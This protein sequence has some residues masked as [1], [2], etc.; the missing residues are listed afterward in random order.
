MCQKK[1]K[2][3]LDLENKKLE[4]EN[5]IGEAKVLKDKTDA[6]FKMLKADS[7]NKEEQLKKLNKETETYL[8]E[9]KKLATTKENKDA[10]IKDVKGQIQ[11]LQN[12]KIPQLNHEKMENQE[13]E[14]KLREQ[15]KDLT[16]E[17]EAKVKEIKDIDKEARTYQR[18]ADEYAKKIKT[19]N[20]KLS[21]YLQKIKE[22][23]YEGLRLEDE[24]RRRENEFT[25]KKK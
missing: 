17:N 7:T 14:K 13:K 11:L 16:E 24:I 9:K 8:A 4:L 25:K 10:E 12:K 3:L 18:K 6:E 22:A 21:D 23:K 2:L 1:R 5:K 20:F 15:I 19:Y